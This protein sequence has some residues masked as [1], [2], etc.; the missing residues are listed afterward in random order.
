MNKKESAKFK[1]LELFKD[2]CKAYKE[3]KEGLTNDEIVILAKGMIISYCRTAT[4][5]PFGTGSKALNDY[6][7]QVRIEA[8]KLNKFY[9]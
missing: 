1:A 4:E 5:I 9:T 8:L 2:F 6:Y 7:K 3:Q